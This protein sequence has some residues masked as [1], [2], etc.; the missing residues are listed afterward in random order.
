MGYTSFMAS[1]PA[2]V[3]LA[4]LFLLFKALQLVAAEKILGKEQIEAGVIP[5][6]QTPT[7]AVT[8]L[9]SIGIIAGG[10]WALTLITNDVT[11]VHAGCVLL[12]T[13]FGFSVRSSCRL[14]LVPVVLTIEGA[15][16]M[17]L[18]VSMLGSAWRAR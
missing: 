5:H 18:M 9:W 3:F 15:C 16:R 6:D 4:P 13:L 11:R 14:K 2:S 17:G 12:V 8:V 7:E 1:V 10:I